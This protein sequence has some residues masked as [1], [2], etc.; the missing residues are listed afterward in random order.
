LATV[1]F[2][3]SHL[4]GTASPADADGID[5]RFDILAL[6][7]LTSRDFNGEGHARAVSNQV[8]LAAPPASA[9]AQCVIRRFFRV[10]FDSKA[11][12]AERL[13]RTFVPSMHHKAPSIPPSFATS[14][15]T[16]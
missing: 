11:P 4:L 9:A 13:A 8:E 16:H 14:T 12:A 3:A 15:C 5:H 6:M 2:V 7:A 1:S 10:V